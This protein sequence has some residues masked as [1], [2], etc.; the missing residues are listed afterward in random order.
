MYNH[1]LVSILFLQ[2]R[3][4]NL[5]CDVYLVDIFQHLNYVI[6]S[7][8]FNVMLMKH[9]LDKDDDVVCFISCYSSIQLFIDA[10]L[11]HFVD[12]KQHIHVLFFC[13]QHRIHAFLFF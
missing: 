5:Q 6:V 13:V 11:D 7:L 3:L 4:C 10:D 12:K 2:T 9:V 1:V 8:D